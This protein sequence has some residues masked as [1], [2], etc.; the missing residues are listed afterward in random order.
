[1]NKKIFKRAVAMMMAAVLTVGAALQ[2]SNVFA[3]G[4]DGEGEN[5]KKLAVYDPDVR[6][7]LEKEEVAVAE[8][9]VIAAG[10]GFDIAND[11]EGI[12]Y[13]A[14][15]VAVSFYP[16]LGSFDGNK[17]GDYDTY[18]KA[19]PVSGRDAYLVHRTITVE[20]IADTQIDN[21]ESVSTEDD[22]GSGDEE[23]PA[24]EGKET[25]YVDLDTKIVQG[26]SIQRA[27]V[28]ML[29]AAPASGTKDGKDSMKV[30]ASGYARYCGHSMGIK[31]ISESGD[32]Y[33]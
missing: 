30:G 21:T 15:K 20:E 17:P 33:F 4:S 19:E 11:L 3:S 31:Y 23:E 6:T 32:Y 13:D 2:G 1:M 8:D 26:L 22:P 9:I 24:P 25:E 10:Y 29:K 14:D 18:Y 12:T 16:D 28:A 27:P 5:A 7:D